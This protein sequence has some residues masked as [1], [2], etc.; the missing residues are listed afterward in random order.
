LSGPVHLDSGDSILSSA[1]GSERFDAFYHK[2][3]PRRLIVESQSA[4][5]YE[6]QSGH[7]YRPI[8]A[9]PYYRLY[10]GGPGI[11]FNGALALTSLRRRQVAGLWV[12]AAEAFATFPFL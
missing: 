9:T 5:P 7:S 3:R 1:L 2:S 11:G 4:M 10:E 6:A 12:V 8:T